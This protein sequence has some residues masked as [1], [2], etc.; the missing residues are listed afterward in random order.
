MLFGK[1]KM[2]NDTKGYGF[3]NREDGAGDIFFHTTSAD[4]R[5]VPTVCLRV[6]FDT[7]TSPKGLRAIKVT[8]A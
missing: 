8:E 3:I 4:H 2:F 5:L 1:I 7:E 6:S